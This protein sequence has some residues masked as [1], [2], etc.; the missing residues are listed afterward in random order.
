M[1]YFKCLVILLIVAIVGCEEESRID[2]IPE[3][4][5]APSL[6]S[7]IEVIPNNGGGVIKFDVPNDPNFLCAKAVYDIRDGV[8]RELKTSVYTDSLVIAGY[9]DTEEHTIKIYSVGKNEVVSDQPVIVK[10]TPLTPPV[11]TAFETL[12]IQTGF[13]SIKMTYDN[14]SASALIVEVYMDTTAVGGSE[15]QNL[16]ILETFYT[17]NAE[18]KLAI[19]DLESKE[20]TFAVKFRDPFGNESEFKT[21]TLT[22][23]FEQKI[24][25]DNMKD[26]LLSDRPEYY[27]EVGQPLNYLWNNDF[28]GWHYDFWASDQKN[29]PM[30]KTIAIDFGVSCVLSRVRWFQR[31]RYEWKHATP[32]KWEL[33]GSNEPVADWSKWT[34]IQEMG[35]EYKPSGLPYPGRTGEDVDYVKANGCNFD[36][37][38]PIGP[39]RYYKIKFLEMN[40]GGSFILLKEIEFYGDVK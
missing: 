1:K 24:P 39:F 35:P 13:G 2:F 3:G 33:Y 16:T 18:G 7:I 4:G 23:Y 14:P 31:D 34:L 26:M 40:D 15:P 38:T 29:L 12:A 25:Q 17:S 11:M 5:G 20:T 32:S 9:G 6:V 8:S 19:R 27:N 28:T 36:I 21:V 22:P 37:D 30:P 10:L